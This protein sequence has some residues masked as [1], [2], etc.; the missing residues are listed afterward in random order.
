MERIKFIISRKILFLSL[1]CLSLIPALKAQTL[2][3]SLEAESGTLTLPAKVKTVA[4]YSGN[5]Y[6]GD[7]NFGSSI[8]FT[9]VEI[10]QEG[11]YEFKT[12][13][14]SMQLRSIA[15]KINDFPEATSTNLTT[16]PDWN[17]PPVASM[18]THIYLNQGKNTIKI[19]PYPNQQG[20]GGPNMDKFEI[21]TTEIAAP[22]SIKLSGSD[23]TS[24]GQTSQIA[25]TILPVGS[26]YGSIKW[27]VDNT[28][29]AA[30][31]DKGVL[32]PKKNGTVK[33]K[34]TIYFGSKSL[35]DEIEIHISGQ[36]GAASFN[37]SASEDTNP[38]EM[39]MITG[40][41]LMLT[42]NFEIYT[43]LKE[44][45]FTFSR[46]LGNGNAIQ[47]GAGATAGT[48]IE[49][50]NPIQA[51]TTG[52]VRITINLT[53]KTYTVLPITALDIVGNAVPGGTDVT[54]GS[55]LT[56]QGNGVWSARHTLVKEFDGNPYFNFVINKSSQEVLKR[57][58]D[59]NQVISQTQATQFGVT[60]DN[61]R[62]NMNGGPYDITIDLKNYTYS[63]SC[64]EINDLKISYMG[65]SVAVGA[66]AMSNFGWAYMYTN[67]LK[68]RKEKGLGLDWTTSNISIG[69]N[70]TS[71]LLD[72]WERDLMSNCSSYVLYALSL[73]NE[74]IHENGEPAYN[75]YRDNML[76]AIKQA[77][78]AGIVPVMANNYTR[79]DFNATDYNYVKKLN[80]LIHEWD[81]PSIN[82]LGA[83]DDGAGR[84]ANGY[85]NDNAHPN[86][87]GHEEFFYAM[88]PSL[89]DALEAG[90]A[91]PVR[92]S[93]TSY[94][95]GNKNTDKSIVLIPENTVHPFTISFDM[96][97]SGK[98]LVA[99]FENQI[100]NGFLKIDDDGKL[101]YET[102]SEKII[103]TTMAV[104][105]GQWKRIT[106]THYYAWGI[107]MLYVDKVKVG[108][109]YE[110]LC[111]KK[112]VL[113]GADSPDEIAYREL[114]FWRAGMNAEEIEYVNNG[115]MMKS[116]LEIYAPLGGAEPLVNLAQST[117]TLELTNS[118]PPVGGSPLISI[119]PN[120]GLGVRIA[121]IHSY[122]GGYTDQGAENLL[123]DKDVPANKTKKWSYNASSHSVIIEL[124]DFY[125]VDK[126]V[127]DDCKTLEKYE[128]VPEYY[129][130]VSTT[131]TGLADWQEVVHETGQGEVTRK[132]KEITPTKA[133][134]IKFVPK[135]ITT[136]RIFSFQFYGRKSVE[137]RYE[138]ELISVGKPVLEQQTSPDIQQAA[139]ALFDGNKNTPNGKWTTSNGDKYVVVDLK[140]KYAISEFKL[141]DAKS[142]N[143]STQNIDGYKISVSSDLLSWEKLVD[144]TGKS[145]E[146]IKTE[147][148]NPAKEARYVKLEIPAD[149]MGDEK[150][151]NL[152][153]FEIFK[154]QVSNSIK[155]TSITTQKLTV[156]PNPAKRGD[157]VFL[158]GTG[159]LKIYSI[160]GQLVYEQEKYESSG[161]PTEN[162]VSG[163][164][165][166]RLTKNQM[167]EQAKLLIEN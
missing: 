17:A 11:T 134:Y 36:L 152:Y 149:R 89:F 153:E 35:S 106:L 155:N 95:L 76:K 65:S 32:S 145:S 71:A 62:T 104:N 84:W 6:V 3:K 115:K 81:L 131:G 80:L 137:S 163:C 129:I 83:I 109:I 42:N 166:I 94:P 9:D 91:L 18:S 85:M 130:Y 43:S 47:Y 113:A 13:Y 33:V 19:T 120:D 69:G 54:K 57:I 79:G 50:G 117:N 29:V 154:Q 151:I 45:S 103:R 7:N 99:W 48:L 20:V 98:G 78:D 61:F 96:Q 164:Y 66:G 128:N 14:T 122:T 53:N 125:D 72:R 110:K 52:P 46:D 126:F 92:I 68:E 39:R 167:T 156:H 67:L 58:K 24:A 4:G 102:P 2:V 135:G 150:K 5:A 44:G 114:F 1:L 160:Q 93:R 23:I 161:I 159:H 59:T 107:T 38:V 26:G 158:N 30:I 142:I 133:R 70:S 64:G 100:G 77:R 132:I 41:D 28:S 82:T 16:T 123:L 101:I 105:D 25:T 121:K 88:V 86:T 146:N 27:E 124:S 108:E 112:F 140:D 21:Y 8:V 87:A 119:T 37:G 34:A 141:Y 144:V 31:S 60:V 56:Y 138:K 111:P 75:S 49:N 63:V 40:L 157:K 10:A 116:S 15:V 73:G 22:T 97:T 55:P 90:K 51:T 148:I 118:T 147:V 127:I 136:I 139:V 162:L 143:S 74:G 12:Y 165:I